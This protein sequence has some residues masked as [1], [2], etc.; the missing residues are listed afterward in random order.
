MNKKISAIALAIVASLGI[1]AFAQTPAA[2]PNKAA[3]CPRSAACAPAKACGDSCC[4]AVFF[5]GITL[6]PEQQTKIAAIKADRQK[7]AKEAR[8]NRKADRKNC[9]RDYLNKMKEVL[10][11]EQYVVFLENMV[12]NRPD[13]HK[14]FRGHKMNGRHGDGARFAGKAD[15]HKAKADCPVRKADKKK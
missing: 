8:E 1:S 11:P 5:E 12:V 14:A 3:D 9:K 6:T 7:A 13:G 10:T 4:T 2:C 15:C